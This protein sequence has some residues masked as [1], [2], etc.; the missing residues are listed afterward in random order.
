[1]TRSVSQIQETSRPTS[2][3]RI[4]NSSTALDSPQSPLL[5]GWA[6]KEAGVLLPQTEKERNDKISSRW[7][8]FANLAS[9]TRG[10]NVLSGSH[11]MLELLAETHLPFVTWFL[12]VFLFTIVDA[13]LIDVKNILIVPSTCRGSSQEI[14][15]INTCI[16][17]KV[18]FKKQMSV[19]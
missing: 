17:H 5:P 12:R 8:L 7:D 13:E 10:R 19:W 1:M 6:G 14:K 15:A 16:W 11:T 4:G 9:A 3:P 18:A 2:G